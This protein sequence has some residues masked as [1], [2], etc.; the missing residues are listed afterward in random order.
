M[1]G[2]MVAESVMLIEREEVA[3]PDDYPTDPAF[4]KWAHEEGSSISATR[5]SSDTPPVA[6]RG[7]GEVTLQSYTQLRTLGRSPR[8]CWRRFSAA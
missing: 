1:M 3:V 2:R 4:K 6:A 5:R 8:N 7:A